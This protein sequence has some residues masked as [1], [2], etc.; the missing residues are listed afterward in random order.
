MSKISYIPNN[1]ENLRMKCLACG[2][3]KIE[4]FK[5]RCGKIFCSSCSPNSFEQDEVDDSLQVTCPSCGSQA[6]FV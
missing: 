5:C 3:E 6:L 2:D 4:V 1:T